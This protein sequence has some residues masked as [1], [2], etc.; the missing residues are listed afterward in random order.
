MAERDGQ[1]ADVVVV[2]V[3]EGNG[4]HLFFGDQLIEREAVAAFALRMGAGVQEQAVSFNF[5]E[6]GAERPVNDG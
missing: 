6:P 2:A 4:L 3:G 5:G 1:R